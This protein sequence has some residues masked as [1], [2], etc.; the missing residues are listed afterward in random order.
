MLCSW[1][2][3]SCCGNALLWVCMGYAGCLEAFLWHSLLTAVLPTP[4]QRFSLSFR[5]CSPVIHVDTV[6]RVWLAVLCFPTLNLLFFPSYLPWHPYFF[7]Q[8]L[9]PKSDI[10]FIYNFIYNLSP[11]CTPVA[12]CSTFRATQHCTSPV[13]GT[14]YSIPSVVS[15]VLWLVPE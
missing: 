13:T 2:Y 6:S 3:T 7:P 5:P 11:K 12:L 15:L 1:E 10:I 8:L 9:E 14:G 4:V